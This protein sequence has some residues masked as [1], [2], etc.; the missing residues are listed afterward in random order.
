MTPP[1]KHIRDLFARTLA[2]HEV[3]VPPEI[4]TG[5]ENRLPSPHGS[6]TA[7]S[8]SLS[9]LQWLGIA[10]VAG[11]IAATSIYLASSRTSL[12]PPEV[13]L[14]EDDSGV[15]VPE[16][17]GSPAAPAIPL[18]STAENG[19]Q[20]QSRPVAR[21]VHE[22]SE[23]SVIPDGNDAA[24][25]EGFSPPADATH[26]SDSPAGTQTAGPS[27]HTPATPPV[28]APPADTQNDIIR[29]FS[30]RIV[31]EEQM[32][33]FFFPSND[34][35][36]HYEW[37]FGDGSSSDQ[38]APGHSYTEPGTYTVSLTLSTPG[39]GKF[40]SSQEIEVVRPGFLNLPNIFTPNGDG[41]N[42]VFDPM[43]GA[44]SI[45]GIV[46]MIIADRQGR[47]VFNN[48][49]HPVW[50]GNLPG[51]EPCEDGVYSYDI[52]A[53]DSNGKTIRRTGLVQLFRR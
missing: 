8:G 15:V 9:T 52:Q 27:P 23:E 30:A 32:R 53:L 7:G 2:E 44:E 47:V 12:A 16:T 10:A 21:D 26:L 18:P 41:K 22:P 43:L 50:T 25:E 14:K 13:T 24:A 6:A 28:S 19:D 1:D 5:L 31:D 11:V 35:A 49:E 45:A 29:D 42:D 34:R 40:F 37:D 48:P 51:G 20:L 39:G 3:P 17:S 38:M 36:A 33:W 4:W 46:Q